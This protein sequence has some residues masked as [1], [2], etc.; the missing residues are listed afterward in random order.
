MIYFMPM[1]NQKLL[2]EFFSNVEC[3]NHPNLLNVIGGPVCLP[4]IKTVAFRTD[5]PDHIST[6]KQFAKTEMSLFH[7]LSIFRQLTSAI[8]SLNENGIIHRDVHPTRLHMHNGVLKFNIFGLPY[9]FKKLM[10]SQTN[11][12]HLNYSAPELINSHQ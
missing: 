11:T 9:N 2:L 1:L 3:A 8:A 7:T 6:W 12:G 5:A 10:K 4:E